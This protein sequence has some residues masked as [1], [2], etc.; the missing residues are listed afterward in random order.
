MTTLIRG[1]FLYNREHLG[2]VYIKTERLFTV[3]Y[4]ECFSIFF[5][6]SL[7]LVLHAN[8]T[9]ASYVYSSFSTEKK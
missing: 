7:W 3:Q 4:L 8:W 1:M 6:H 2:K 9:T 5:P